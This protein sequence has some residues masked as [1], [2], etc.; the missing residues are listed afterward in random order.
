MIDLGPQEI[1][2]LAFF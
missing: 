1:S 2:M